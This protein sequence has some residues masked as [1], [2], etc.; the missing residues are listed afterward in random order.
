MCSRLVTRLRRTS[1]RWA[2]PLS[3]SIAA[4]SYLFLRNL[5]LPPVDVGFVSSYGVVDNR[6]LLLIYATFLMAVMVGPLLAAF[7]IPNRWQAP[8]IRSSTPREKL[9]GRKRHR[10]LL[11]LLFGLPLSFFLIGP[12]VGFAPLNGHELVHLG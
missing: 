2:L 8:P 6:K 5:N 9:P 1:V 11:L 12:G 7:V 3:F 10:Y 4:A